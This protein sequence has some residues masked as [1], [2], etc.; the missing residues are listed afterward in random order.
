MCYN[1]T[2][3]L[4]FLSVFLS[5][6][7][8]RRT[9]RHDFSTRTVARLYA[10]NRH[11]LFLSLVLSIMIISKSGCD[12]SRL[13]RLFIFGVDYSRLFPI[14]PDY[15][16]LF[17]FQLTRDY[18]RF[19]CGL[20]NCDYSDYFPTIITIILLPS[21]YF[22]YYDYSRLF[23]LFTIILFS[24]D[25]F[26]YLFC[27]RLFQLLRLFTIIPDYCNYFRLFITLAIISIILFMYDYSRL[28]FSCFD[29]FDFFD[30]FHYFDFFFEFSEQSKQADSHLHNQNNQNNRK[31]RNNRGNNRE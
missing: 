12:Y 17:F 9:F 11:S 26:D 7:K 2:L 29:F 24:C 30:F 15:S 25:Y 8:L 4:S 21:D 19:C 16:R 27:V 5:V 6:T 13:L 20:L 3:K 18:L 28:F 1:Q 23:Q 22:M 14:I 31:N 10:T